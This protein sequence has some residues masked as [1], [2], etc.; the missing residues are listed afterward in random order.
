MKYQTILSFNVILISVNLLDALNVKCAFGIEKKTWP[1]D[2]PL[3]IYTCDLKV[4]FVGDEMAIEEIT[5]NQDQNKSISDAKKNLT[6]DQKKNHGKDKSI[7]DVKKIVIK[8][9]VEIRAIPR[10]LFKFFPNINR[11]EIRSTSISKVVRQDFYGL[12]VEIIDIECNQIETIGSNA[13]EYQAGI[14]KVLRVNHNPIKSVG[15]Y[16]FNGMTNLES[17]YFYNVKCLEMKN[18]EYN[19]NGVEKAF[20]DIVQKCPPSNELIEEYFNH[21]FILKKLKK[22]KFKAN[23]EQKMIELSKNRGCHVP[24]LSLY[25]SYGFDSFDKLI[26]KMFQIK[27]N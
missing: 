6:K 4:Q 7:S 27:L 16:V 23:L 19:R 20:K 11:L 25:P 13:F 18:I 17:L 15:L 9:Q 14:M 2:K 3:Q 5:G 24:Q 12:K 8:D 22:N 26:G 10:K 1:E 21:D